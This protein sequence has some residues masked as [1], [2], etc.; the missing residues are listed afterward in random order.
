VRDIA[1]GQS[2][3]GSAFSNGE[4]AGGFAPGPAPCSIPLGNASANDAARCGKDESLI[5][6]P[7]AATTAGAATSA[8]ATATARAATSARAATTAPVIPTSAPPAS[9][10]AL[11]HYISRLCITLVLQ[12]LPD[13]EP[14]KG[15]G[16]GCHCGFRDLSSRDTGGSREIRFDALS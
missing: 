15:N 1:T 16:H 10:V 2:Q 12:F 11:T 7:R 8:G 6:A 5:L 13:R 14:E 9:A 4:R 3:T